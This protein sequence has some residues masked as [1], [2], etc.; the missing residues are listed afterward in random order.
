M[1]RSKQHAL[2]FLLGAIL[3]GGVLGFTAD[4]VIVHDREGAVTEQETRARFYNSLALDPTQ[5]AQFDSIF[6]GRD[7]EFR[8]VL[9]PVRP[10]LKEIKERARTSMRS[11]LSDA[12]KA[13]FERFLVEQKGDTTKRR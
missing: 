10:R 1:E 8:E 3:V 4:R 7:R 6:D 5:R 9:S 12:Q 2:M 13:R 11:H